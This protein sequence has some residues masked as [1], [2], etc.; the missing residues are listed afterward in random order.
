[1]VTN[2]EF[3]KGFFNN[4][5]QVRMKQWKTTYLLA[6]IGTFGGQS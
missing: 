3:S 2:G 1:M 6:E 5:A 4:E